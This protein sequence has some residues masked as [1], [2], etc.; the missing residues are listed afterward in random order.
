MDIRSVFE[1][2]VS[3]TEWFNTLK[4]EKKDEL[5]QEDL[6]RDKRLEFLRGAINLQFDS[7][8]SFP[9]MDLEIKTPALI[10]YVNAHGD[11]YCALRLL[12]LDKSLPKLRMRGIT[13]NKVMCWF[14]DQKVDASKY[15][16]FFM[17]HSNNHVYST[18]FIVNK[19]GIFGEI[20]PG[21]HYQLTQGFHSGNVST[22]AFDFKNLSIDEYNPE[23]SSHLLDVFENIKIQDESKAKL[24]EDTLNVKL[25]NGFLPGYF[26][27]ILTKEFGLWFIDYNRVLGDLFT[28]FKINVTQKSNL[29]LSGR[30]VS[31]GSAT[32]R[33]KMVNS[34]QLNA[35]HFSKG[36]I[37]VCEMTTPDFVYL[38]KKAGAIITN[39][40][41]IL[42]HAAIVSRELKVP[43]IV[44]VKNATSILKD[45]DLVE[46]DAFNGVVRKLEVA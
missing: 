43:C 20:I 32:G 28:D 29:K 40:G 36:D 10:E 26:E 39:Q 46:V 23:I 18:I 21:A 34:T 25:V 31:H 44:G 14:K 3:I 45:G 5:K 42:C 7:P 13:V 17:P 35:I 27:T 11:E 38:M 16:A 30:V 37:L 22:F 4:S 8:V 41:G 1:K 9:A 33:V 2:S 19:N 6:T 12:P 24:V 15:A